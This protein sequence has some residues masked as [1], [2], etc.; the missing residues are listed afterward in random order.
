[1]TTK[2]THLEAFAVRTEKKRSYWT[3]IG[4]AFPNKSEGFT[5][6]LDAVPAPEDGQFRIVVVPPKAKNEDIPG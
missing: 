4:A 2:T 1:M 3:K 5:L 6:V